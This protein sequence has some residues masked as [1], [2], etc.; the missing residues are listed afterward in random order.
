MMARRALAISI[1]LVVVSFALRCGS[2]TTTTTPVG[3]V[4]TLIGDTPICDV[5][6][7]RFNLTQLV[8]YYSQSS[9]GVTI[10]N[11][12]STL[13]PLDLAGLRG[14]FTVLNNSSV[15]AGTYDRIS[16]GLDASSMYLYDPSVNPPIS[17]LTETLTTGTTLTYPISP[18]LVI[19][20]S[21]ISVVSLDFDLN[22]SLAANSDGQLTGVVTP[23]AAAT[24]PT[25]V[26]T[27]ASPTLSYG[28][29][30]GVHGFVESVSTSQF[31]SGGTTYTGGVTV[32]LLPSNVS[33]SGGPALTVE[34]TGNSLVCGPT[35]F[36]NQACCQSGVTP[37]MNPACSVAQTPLNGILTGSYVAV[38][39]FVDAN[40]FFQANTLAL[41]PQDIATDQQVPQ[42]VAA[43][44]GP[45][46]SVTKD[47]SG[48]VTGFSMFLRETQP[49]I[50]VVPLDALTVVTLSSGILY[51]TVTPPLY[52]TASPTTAQGTNFA[53]LPFGPAEIAVGEDVIV[54]GIYTLPPT[55]TPPATA[56]PVSVVPSEI[57]L[58]LQTHQGN[59]VSLLAVQPDNR[60]GAF[61]LQPCATLDQQNPTALPIYVFTSPQTVFVNTN[62]LSSLQPQTGLLVKGLLFLEPQSVTINGVTVPAGQLVMLAKQVIQGP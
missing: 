42:Q 15:T 29:V 2:S 60:T 34:A 6:A 50:S 41:G 61:A 22:G 37:G 43:F 11:S 45:V 19:P 25:A 8:L 62:G 44:I 49:A 48:T 21:G 5:L 4:Y 36:S 23:R 1:L 9:S 40:G 10:L 12:V 16:V 7:A 27:T 55:V 18:P 39:G 58:N 17:T 31:L 59:F 53:A 3:T 13:V 54:H 32:Q 35:T 51:N 56:P 24:A 20:A 57:D 26:L 47:T 33:G 14:S 28:D 30:D 38:D 46:L 52:T